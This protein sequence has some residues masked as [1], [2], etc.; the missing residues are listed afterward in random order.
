M[1]HRLLL[2]LL[3]CCSTCLMAEEWGIIDVSVA[4]TRQLPD[5]GSEQESQALLGMPVRVLDESHEWL[6]VETPDGYVAWTLA[7]VVKRVSRSELTAWNTSPQVVVT[8]L[9][10]T[11]LA[12]RNPK[13]A[14]VGDVV[15]GDRLRLLGKRGKYYQVAFPDGREGYLH[16]SLCQPIEK[17]RATLKNDPESI[18]RTAYSLTGVPYMWGGTSP[19]GVD[20]SGFVRT[21]LYLHDIIIPRNSSQ[22][23]LKGQRIEIADDFSNLEPGDL[24]FFGSRAEGGRKERVVHVAFYVGNM[25]FIHS[26]G[27]VH[28]GSFRPSDPNYD[29]YDLGRLLFASRVLPYINKEEGLFTT[30]RHEFYR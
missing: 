10:G 24:L 19:K 23:A 11:V 2:I 6:Q 1:K 14:M 3:W 15:G 22:Q 25:R 12:A 28:E 4:N 27:F 5:Y 16:R 8:S 17:W 7:G 26:I 18:L 30:D 29:A 9:Y 21:T 13:S 20:C